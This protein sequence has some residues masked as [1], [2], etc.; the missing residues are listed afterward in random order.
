MKKDRGTNWR[1]IEI[2]TLDPY[3]AL[4]IEE[5]AVNSVAGG[6]DPVIHF[7][8]WDRKAVT[9]GSFQAYLDEVYDERCAEDGVPVIR[10]QSG[11]GT[12][13]HSPGQEMVFSMI[14][15]PKIMRNDIKESYRV[16][17]DPVIMGLER[18]GI[19]AVMDENNLFVRGS[20]ISGSAQRRQV[21]A[22]LV[23]GTLLYEVDEEEM[24]SY[25]RG[26]R[27]ISS[28]RGT[29]SVY[30]PVT[31][32]SEHVEIPYGDLY[33]VI[34]DSFAEGRNFEIDSWSDEEMET[35]RDLAISR[36][37]DEEWNRKI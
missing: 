8:E 19:G 29:C 3:T 36:Y 5:S 37:G 20:K 14:A 2:E 32:I 33:K 9:I 21:K 16:A 1:L 23:H 18:I 30:K 35:A 17:L 15:G 26:D 34:R 7:W 24:L 11:G 25:I 28:G 6:G 4:G 31:S 27:A 13:Y 10:R 22:V 12:M